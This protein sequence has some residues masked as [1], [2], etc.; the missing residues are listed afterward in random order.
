MGFKNFIR[1]IF[2]FSSVSA[3]GA[4]ADCLIRR[5]HA[6]DESGTCNLWAVEETPD[7]DRLVGL[8]AGSKITA[9]MLQRGVYHISPNLFEVP[10]SSKIDVGSGEERIPMQVEATFAFRIAIDGGDSGGELLRWLAGCSLMK[11]GN[12]AKASAIVA[13]IVDSGKIRE[14]LQS[15]LSGVRPALLE[16]HGGKAV[17]WLDAQG[18]PAKPLPWLALDAEKTRISAKSAKPEEKVVA[19]D[20]KMTPLVYEKKR[21]D[22]IKLIEGILVTAKDLSADARKELDDAVTK[23]RRNSFEI[24]LVGEFQ[25]GKSTLF[26]TICE[27][28]E[29]SP[30]GQGIKTSACKISA[31]SLPD[32]EAEYVDLRWKTDDELMLTMIDI[33]KSNLVTGSEEHGIFNRKDEVTGM[34]VLPNLS[35]GNVREIATKAL[36]REWESYRASPAAYDPDNRG[37]LDLLQISSLILR[38]YGNP[39]LAELRKSTR[40]SVDELK[41]LVVFPKNWADHWLEGEK[42]EWRFEEVPFVFL[43]EAFAHIHCKGLERLGCVVTDCPGLFAGPWDTRV[44]EEAMMNSDAIL[45]LIGGNR[46]VT[47]SDKRAWAHILKTDQGHKVF[48]A[49]NARTSKAHCAQ[50]LL[51]TDFAMIKQRGFNLEAKDDISIFNA[52]LAFN[53]RVTPSDEN[54]WE[55]ETAA[56]VTNYFAFNVLRDTRKIESLLKDRPGLYR[57]SGAEELL[58]KI[59]TSV[60][61][62]K[63]ESIL[64]KG[65]TEKVSAALNALNGSLLV[66]ERAASD[67]LD[68]AQAAFEAA[69]EKLKKF[70]D[71]AKTEVATIIDDPGSANIL[72]DD[73]WQKVYLANAGTMADMISQ[74]IKDRFSKSTTLLKITYELMRAKVKSWFADISAE[75]EDARQRAAA[76]LHEPINEAINNVATSASEG[77]FSNIRTGTNDLFA[78]VYGRALKTAE[79][80]VRDRWNAD[81]CVKNG[82]MEGLELGDVNWTSRMGRTQ[83]DD[84]NRDGTIV[85]NAAMGVLVR[86]I[87]A[88]L[89]GIVVALVVMVVVAG[90]IAEIASAGVALVAAVIAAGFSGVGIAKWLN[91]R[92]LDGMVKRLHDKISEKLNAVFL[93]EKD[94]IIAKVKETAIAEIVYELRSR[95]DVSLR[96][97]EEKFKER[98]QE[99]YKMF[100]DEQANLE[101]VAAKAKKVREEQIEPARIKVSTFHEML[102]PYFRAD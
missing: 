34:P 95:F 51:P 69:R 16:E 3:G 26:D 29:I 41:R 9:Q 53:S 36:A 54:A 93:K 64:V 40:V 83:V 101:E 13:A 43:G 38:F 25:G 67:G 37:R 39:A 60:V 5:L 11:N 91:D 78:T 84:A 89:V 86:K 44:A 77:W 19:D 97:Q 24:V 10:F 65:G 68:K 50:I 18:V 62:R 49:I 17:S 4:P 88:S 15:R 74:N 81:F 96:A 85:Q 70:Q 102:T 98:E 2:G 14:F 47:D 48:F 100:G 72:A 27:G 80:Q 58:S 30:R 46:T 22:L 55:D 52:I 21:N 42:T 61:L 63:F 57:A 79:R 23:L 71:F 6:A 35:D 56:A 33:V 32:N 8:G 87:G 94:N 90:I 76:E 1:R 7:G 99:T 45:Y 73:Y 59:E 12:E 31:V 28:R 75:E 82:V 66:K 20:G 92:I